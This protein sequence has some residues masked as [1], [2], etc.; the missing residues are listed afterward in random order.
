MAVEK[1]ARRNAGGMVF[2]GRRARARLPPDHSAKLRWAGRARKNSVAAAK[3][4]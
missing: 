3:R 4:T 2:I 1:E